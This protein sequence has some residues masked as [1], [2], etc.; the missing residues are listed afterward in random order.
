METVSAAARCTELIDIILCS[1]PIEQPL[2]KDKR[3]F[4]NKIEWLFDTKNI[5]SGLNWKFVFLTLPYCARQR[6]I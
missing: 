2:F 4:P 6:Q 1:R 5:G 3:Y